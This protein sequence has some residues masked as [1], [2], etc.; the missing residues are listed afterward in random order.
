MSIGITT[1][2]AREYLMRMRDEDP[3]SYIDRIWKLRYPVS[4]RRR[5]KIGSW[6]IKRQ[7]WLQEGNV[8]QI[9]K[10]EAK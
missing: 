10:R 3:G 4:K 9:K 8:T 7:E 2:E 6:P 5:A 1:V